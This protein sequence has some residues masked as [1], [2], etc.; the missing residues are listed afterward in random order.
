MKKKA[1]QIGKLYSRFTCSR[2][3]SLIPSPGPPFQCQSKSVNRVP[4]YGTISKPRKIREKQARLEM[5]NRARKEID[6]LQSLTEAGC[7][8]TPSLLGWK[9]TVQNDERYVPGGYITYTLPEKVPGINFDC[10]E[11]LPREERDQ[12]REAFISAWRGIFTVLLTIMYFLQKV[13]VLTE[14]T[15]E[16]AL[17]AGSSITTRRVVI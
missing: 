17:S 3:F 15:T 2:T 1:D 5:D 14:H 12:I 4:H 6:A 13:S 8:S 11:S 7:S 16:N 9:H 10:F